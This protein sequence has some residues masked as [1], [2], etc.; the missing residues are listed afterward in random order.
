[1]TSVFSDTSNAAA[2][3]SQ[4]DIAPLSEIAKFRTAT[5]SNGLR[6]CAE[7][8]PRGYSA[9]FGYFVRTGARD[10]TDAEDGLSHFLEHMLFKGTPT[11]SAADVNRGLDELGGNSNAFTSEE[12]TV[13]YATVLPKYQSRIVDLLTDIM[14]PSL[15]DEDF[16]TERQVILEEIAKY[17]DQPPFGGF[18][19]IMELKFGCRGLGRRILGTTESIS[20]M[21]P[22]TM[23]AYFQRRYHCGNIVLAAAGNL[24]FDALVAQ[25]ETL[26]S[27][28]TPGTMPEN[29]F[30]VA[31]LP[32][33]ETEY[34]SHLPVEI[35]HQAYCLRMLDSPGSGSHDRYAARL[36]AAIL[37]DDGGSRL[38]WE[39]VDTGRAEAA[40]VWSQE[41]LDCGAMF[42]YLIG[43]S[44]VSVASMMPRMS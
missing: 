23:R 33:D 21:A 28:W 43:V 38:F 35:A 34:E 32:V 7:V 29:G 17:E 5:L 25:C 18:E 31:T 16:E 19:R 15:R 10:E 13:Y 26:T 20:G 12:Q 40:S 9:S 4:R 39:L 14:R 36:L 44:P 27:Q 3:L 41:F 8:D 11:R 1:M 6:I 24:D 2:N 30:E 37:G 22:E 42:Q